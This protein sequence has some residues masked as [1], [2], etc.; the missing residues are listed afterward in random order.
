VTLDPAQHSWAASM[1]A[2]GAQ[3][4]EPGEVVPADLPPVTGIA[5]LE[6]LAPGIDRLS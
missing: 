6:I 1:G 5:Y 4:R 3:D 2:G